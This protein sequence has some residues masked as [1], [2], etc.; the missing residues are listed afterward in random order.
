MGAHCVTGARQP[1]AS[2][3]FVPVWPSGG[4]SCTLQAPLP[5]SK[6]NAATWWMCCDQSVVSS[7]YQI[8][9]RGLWSAALSV[10]GRQEL[11]C[12]SGAGSVSPRL[13]RL[14]W[15]CLLCS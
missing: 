7:G 10:Q 11:L 15:G 6:S 13:V 9:R 3:N 12:S 4:R 5:L 14:Q 8:V 2:W 1:A